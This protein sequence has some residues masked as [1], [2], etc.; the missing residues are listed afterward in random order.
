MQRKRGVLLLFLAAVFLV[1]FCSQSSPL[2]PLNIWD[3]ANCLLTVG[4]AMKSGAVLYRD[5]YEQKG[6][7]LYLIHMLAACIQDSSFFGVYLFEILALFLD[8]L[9][10]FRILYDR[11][12]EVY[13]LFGA[14]LF[15]AL[16]VSSA[17]FSRGDSAEEFCLPCIMGLLYLGEKT[18]EKKTVPIWMGILSGI[19]GTIKYTML[20]IPL[21]LCVYRI[22][23]NHRR[24]R[25]LV[26]FFLWF[27]LGMLLPFLA[28]GI[29]FAVNGALVDAYKAY[30]FNNI[31]LYAG[32]RTDLLE[33][34]S[35][36][37]RNL[38]WIWLLGISA[39]RIFVD[40]VAYD[41]SLYLQF[42]VLIFGGRMWP[43]TWLALMPF[44]VFGIDWLLS[45]IDGK[46][47]LWLPGMA[48]AMALAAILTPNAFLRGQPR[49]ELAQSQIAAHIPADASF[50]Q[51]SH[52]DDGVYLLS[53]TL[54][55]EKY[56]VRLNVQSQ[57]MLD[58]MDFA[59]TIG[60]PEY[61][62]ITWR[63]LPE[64]FDRYELIAYATGY[65]DL[66]R[67]NKDFF[68]YRRSAPLQED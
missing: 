15:G 12:S 24:P 63:M 3:D 48:A 31:F 2:Y 40:R 28:W 8:L 43:Y 20:A 6:P 1:S 34:L 55:E 66:N 61:V 54:P 27:L 32:E 38:P 46:R 52:L 19:I 11:R 21:G 50:L 51:Y 18:G 26:R 30:I 14:I 49:E 37:K 45:F 41:H 65:D 5:I 35:I 17:T 23:L 64:Q 16:V 39:Y 59:L 67:K 68:L 9:L 7:T 57:E 44:L 47:L 13:S 62:L 58:A 4:R 10:A 42:L 36:L 53:G 60:K 33:L 22:T 56:F 29:Y 25:R